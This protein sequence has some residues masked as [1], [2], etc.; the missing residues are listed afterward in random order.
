M[1]EAIIKQIRINFKAIQNGIPAKD[2]N[3]GYSLNKLKTVNE[4][5]YIDYLEE[6]KNI[7]AKLKK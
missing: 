1:E 2:T 4:G 6:Y 7:L 3:I 5:L